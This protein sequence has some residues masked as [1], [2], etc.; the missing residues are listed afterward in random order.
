[1]QDKML[2]YSPFKSIGYTNEGVVFVKKRKKGKKFS[3]W[4]TALSNPEKGG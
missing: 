1:M 2:N 4:N 3:L